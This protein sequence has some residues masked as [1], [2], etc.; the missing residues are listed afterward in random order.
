MRMMRGL[1]GY[2]PLALVT[3]G[4][5]AVGMLAVPLPQAGFAAGPITF[6]WGRAGDADTLDNPVSTNGETSEVTTQ[7]FNTLVRL[8]PG[9]V[10]VEPD[11]ATSWSVSPDG[12]VWT[13]KLRKGVTF[14]DG[15]PWNAEA[16]K[17]NIDRWADKNNPYHQSGT[18]FYYWNDLLADSFK[19]ARAIDPETLQI[20][21]SAPFGAL[22]S[23]LSVIAFDFA[24]P[25]SL[26]EYGGQGAGQHPVGTGPF[27]FVEWVRDDHI[28][29]VANSAFFRRGFP[30]MPR[31]IYRV[32]KD[33]AARYLALKAGGA[34]AIELPNPDDV[35][36]AQADPNLKV[37]FRSSFNTG[38]LHFNMNHPQ[39]KD[40][41]VREAV[42]LAINKQAIVQ[43]LYGGFGEVADQLMPPV[44]WGRSP[45]VKAYP[46][47]PERARKLLAEAGYANG[48]AVDFWYIPV[49]R[50]Y[51]PQGKEIGTAIANDLGKVGIKATLVTEDWAVYGKDGRETLKFPVYMV[52]WIGDTG[53]PDDWLGFFFTRTKPG[54][55]R[56]SYDNP[57]VRELVAKARTLSSQADRAKVYA[58]IQEIVT[59]DIPM[60][61]IAHSKTPLVMLKAVEGLIPHPNGNEYMETVSLR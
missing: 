60:V 51:F 6:V 34:H 59:N 16:A 17:L 20:V 4:V 54:A 55:T 10:E 15:T 11:L 52:G 13:F 43:G 33:N 44:M 30:K 39:F 5:L 42:A 29:L 19:E 7:V 58:Q 49:S 46:Y 47:D 36:T 53:D 35:K 40:R 31:V 22:L 14:H 27:K 41:R 2:I 24:S 21:T 18:D 32:I 8:R 25:A 1:S 23:D 48:F 3:A 38:W 26:K 12:T 37:A 28:T 61:P 56:Y 9:T 45:K 57:T 50:P